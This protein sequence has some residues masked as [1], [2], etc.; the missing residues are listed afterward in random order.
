MK[1][2]VHFTFGQVGQLSECFFVIDS[3][4]SQHFAVDV[5][6]RLFQAVHQFVVGK[7]VHTGG[8]IDPGNPEPTKVAFSLAP[9]TVGIHS[10]TSSLVVLRF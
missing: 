2:S 7:A 9:V 8:G 5:H 6:A 10:V 4:I 3:Q 1:S